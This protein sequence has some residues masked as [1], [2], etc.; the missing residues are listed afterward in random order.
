MKRKLLVVVLALVCASMVFAQGS[1]EKKAAD[2]GTVTLRFGWWGGDSRHEAYIAAANR[3]MELNPNVKIICEYGGFD[4]YREKLYTQLAGGNAPDIFQN[5]YT[6]LQEQASM[7]DKPVVRDFNDFRNTVDFSIY[8]EGFL[9]ANT[10]YDGKI[11]ALPSSVNTFALVANKAVLDKIG[12]DYNADW[13]WD[14]FFKFNSELKAIDSSLYFENGLSADSI[15]MYWFLDYLAQLTGKPFDTDY[16][17]NYTVDELIQAF[18]FFKKYFSEGVTEPLGTCELYTGN[19]AQNPTWINGKSGILFG[20]L[21]TLENYVNAMGNYAKDAAVIKLPMMKDAK[22]PFNKMNVGQCFSISASVSERNAVEAAKFLNW[23]DTDP[24]A[25]TIL[26]LSRGIP[27]SEAQNQALADAGLI[28]PLVIQAQQFA[29][30]QGQGVG[31]TVLSRNN[32][33]TKIG[34]D[35]ISALAFD[36]ITPEEAAKQYYSLVTDKLEELKSSL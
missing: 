9:E 11:L 30:E 13:T 20:M 12:F 34:K 27:V 7:S 22:D 31:Q 25:G 10:M 32:E 35:I 19:F 28:N 21:S 14:D 26:K 23:M 33:I 18:T 24:E 5:H 4:G 2:D 16:Q 3:Y 29:V 36:R 15:H 8:P 17:L 6:W 1:P